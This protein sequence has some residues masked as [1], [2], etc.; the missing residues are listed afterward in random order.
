[1]MVVIGRNE[2]YKIE[3][4]PMDAHPCQ[5]KEAKSPQIL[6]GMLTT[7]VQVCVLVDQVDH[8]DSNPCGLQVSGRGRR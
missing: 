5:V 2:I 4:N 6:N 3:V 1:M 8:L 7:L